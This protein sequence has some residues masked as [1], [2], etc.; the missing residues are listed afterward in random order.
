M[1]AARKRP[2]LA[3][4]L[5]TYLPS[6][7]QVFVKVDRDKVLKLGVRSATFTARCKLSWAEIL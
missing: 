1:A 6:V 7:P 2:E 4:I 5:T 3:G